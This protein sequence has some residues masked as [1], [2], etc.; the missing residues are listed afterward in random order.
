[1][2]SITCELGDVS[3]VL[4]LPAACYIIITLKHNS[5]HLHKTFHHLN[6]RY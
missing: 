2:N 3:H 1:M 4:R 6:N 5:I